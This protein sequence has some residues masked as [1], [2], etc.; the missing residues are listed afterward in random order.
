MLCENASKL[1][2]NV[3]PERIDEVIQTKL[4][5][6][7]IIFQNPALVDNLSQNIGRLPHFNICDIVT[8]CVFLGMR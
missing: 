4:V 8:V 6:G 5:C 7:D 1:N 3:D 2:T